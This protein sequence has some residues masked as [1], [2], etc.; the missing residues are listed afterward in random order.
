MKL[1][2][3]KVKGK[4]APKKTWKPPAVQPALPTKRQRDEDE[5]GGGNDGTVG[6]DST[7]NPRRRRRYFKP[8]KPAAP[9]EQLP[10]EILERIILMSRNL[11]FLRSSLRIGYRFSSRV[12]LTELLEAAFAPTWDMWFG[13]PRDVVLHHRKGVSD[14]ALVPGDPD[15]QTAVIA[16]KWANTAL[17]LEAQQKWYR[18]NGGPGRLVEHLQQPQDKSRAELA[19]ARWMS[20]GAA[21]AG[22]DDVVAGR[23]ERDWQSFRRSC[24]ELFS[25]GDAIA[26]AHVRY[27]THSR[28]PQYMELHPL[29]RVPQRL[30]AAPFDW[31]RARTWYWLVR[32]SAGIGVRSGSWESTRIAYDR[33]LNLADKELAVVLLILLSQ[34]RAFQDWPTFLVEQEL[35]EIARQIEHSETLAG[36]KLW[37]YAGAVMGPVGDLRQVV[38]KF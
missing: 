36:R 21:A 34:L 22:A 33:I 6:T 26:A 20:R 18:R 5:G 23:F 35:G 1:T 3:I 28:E 19:L 12:F 9:V 15:F 2:P 16:C 8:K 13:Y 11:N 7:N 25:S 10:A 31:E 29:T 30:L 37:S 14:S 4:A 17:I 38:H 24:V 27:T 32:G